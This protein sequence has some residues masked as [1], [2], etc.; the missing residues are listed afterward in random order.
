MKLNS[1]L[2]SSEGLPGAGGGTFK[3]AHR[4]V[5]WKE[6]LV[7]WKSCQR[8]HWVSFC[9]VSLFSPEL[10]IQEQEG[11]TNFFYDLLLEDKITFFIVYVL[12]A[13]LAHAQGE[14]I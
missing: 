4:H 2:Q 7:P 6:F 10:V 1:M 8:S 14:E 5:Y 12:Y 9:Y 3:M 13:N 11:N